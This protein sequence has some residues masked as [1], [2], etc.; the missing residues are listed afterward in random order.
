MVRDPLYR[1]RDL[2]DA[3]SLIIRHCKTDGFSKTE[4][5]RHAYLRNEPIFED[6]GAMLAQRGFGTLAKAP[7]YCSQ[8]GHTF[9]LRAAK[10][11]S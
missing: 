7:G 10:E 5:L 1:A 2:R 4:G 6:A 9:T 3:A 11:V 8:G